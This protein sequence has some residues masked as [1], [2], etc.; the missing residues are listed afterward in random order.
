MALTSSSQAPLEERSIYKMLR[1]AQVAN[2]VEKFK[3]VQE[4]AEEL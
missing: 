3:L 4:A 2:L 1:D